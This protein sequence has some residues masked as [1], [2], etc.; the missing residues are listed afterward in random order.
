MSQKEDELTIMAT[1]VAKLVNKNIQEI[2]S[3]ISNNIKDNEPHTFISG[4]AALHT[5][6][7]YYEYKM[8]R[9]GIP[10]KAIEKAKQSAEDYVLD[11][12]ADQMGTVAQEKGEA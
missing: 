10:P 3:V 12:I 5:V 8:N 4:Y 2:T 6:C 1:E 9:M 7:I 11:V